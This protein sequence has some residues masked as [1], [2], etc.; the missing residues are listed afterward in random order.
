MTTSHVTRSASSNYVT[1]WWSKT[2]RSRRANRSRAS[3]GLLHRL[4]LRSRPFE[5][6]SDR[7][8]EPRQALVRQRVG[9][10]KTATPVQVEQ[11]YFAP[12][13]VDHDDRARAGCDVDADL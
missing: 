13:R 1:V 5:E 8:C 3:L 10:L 6:Q 2:R 9:L 4:P 12:L 11:V 7:H